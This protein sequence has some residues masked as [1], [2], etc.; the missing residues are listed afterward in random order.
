MSIMAS[1]CGICRS[2]FPDL[3]DVASFFT[4]PGKVFSASPDLA[5]LVSGSTVVLSASSLLFI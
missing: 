4:V 2:S 3:E 1:G 5:G